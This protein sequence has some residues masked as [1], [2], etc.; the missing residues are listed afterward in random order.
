VTKEETMEGYKRPL[1][2]AFTERHR[3]GD[4]QGQCR[5]LTP[6]ELDARVEVGWDLPDLMGVLAAWAKTMRSRWQPQVSHRLEATPLP[7]A[8]APSQG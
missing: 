2:M 1:V 3:T 4:Q 8:A 7:A 5:Q 6:D